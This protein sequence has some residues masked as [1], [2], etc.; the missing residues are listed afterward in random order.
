MAH[1]LRE[2]TVLLVRHNPPILNSIDQ[3]DVVENFVELVWHISL[4]VSIGSSDLVPSL[5][6]TVFQLL[7]K[8]VHK[9]RLLRRGV[10]LVLGLLQLLRLHMQHK[11]SLQL[12]LL[13]VLLD[14]PLLVLYEHLAT[15]LLLDADK[16]SS[17][18]DANVDDDQED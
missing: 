2:S 17:K 11:L 12:P 6:L 18:D 8:G 16:G 15:A 13:V 5:R 1:K 9:L 7:T 3:V 4:F 14:Q 10:L